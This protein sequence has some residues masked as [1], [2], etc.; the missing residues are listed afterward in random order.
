MEMAPLEGVGVRPVEL[1]DIAGF[2]ACVDAV[3]RE[4]EYLAYLEAFSLQ[5]TA[6]FVTTNIDSGNP[7]FVAAAGER[8][9]GWCDI[10]RET[11]PVYSH[12]AALGMGVLEE[13]RGRGIGE[14]LIRAALD[15]AKTGG[16]ERV[17]LSVYAKNTRAASLY[18]KIGFVHEGTRLKGKKLDGV[19]D[20]VHLMV[21]LI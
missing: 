7:H 8:I 11:I 5:Q 21:F 17:E 9:V 2:R 1:A 12:C 16:F 18:R 4:R 15:Q 14:R 19:Y 20:D 13:F 6:A 3:M 10:R